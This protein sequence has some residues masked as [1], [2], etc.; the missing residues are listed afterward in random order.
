MS[1]ETIDRNYS[2]LLSIISNESAEF[3]T[4]LTE[5]K[6]EENL[7]F[8]FACEKYR[9]MTKSQRKQYGKKMCQKFLREDSPMAINVSD[10]VKDTVIRVLDDGEFTVGVFNAC[11]EGV[12][13]M[14]SGDCLMGYLRSG[15]NGRRRSFD[16]TTKPKKKRISWKRKRKGSVGSVSKGM[17]RFDMMQDFY[18]GIDNFDDMFDNKGVLRLFLAYLNEVFRSTLLTVLE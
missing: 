14:L 16:A 6:Q 8:Y 7:Y 10:D 15:M 9:N 5:N 11:L 2:T 4:F 12:V 1:L 13:E 3:L 18:G 17:E